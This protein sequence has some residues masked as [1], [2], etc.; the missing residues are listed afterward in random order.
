MKLTGLKPE[1]VFKYFEEIS[2]V[3]RGSGN[4]NDIADYCMEFANKNSLKAFRD[5]ANNIIIFKDATNGYENSAPV[6]LQGHLDIVCQKEEGNAI[7]FEKDGLDIYVDGDYITARGTTLGADNGIAIAMIMAILESS[8]LSHPPIEAI[9]TT[10]E[11]I[12]MI[13]ASQLD[14]SQIKGTRMINLD[15]EEQDKLTVSCAG[16]SEFEITIPVIRK[17]MDGSIVIL[18]LVGLK[19]GHSGIEIGSG[20]VNASI[21]AGRFLNAVSNYEIISINGG[22]KSNAITNCCTV[23]L[24]T[25]EPEKLI[26]ALENYGETVKKEIAE[27]E[28]G[29]EI[30]VKAGDA[31]QFEVLDDRAKAKLVFALM[32]IPN[33]VQEMSA[34]IDGLVETSLNLGI[35]K[36]ET[37]KITMVSA[38]RSNKQ[39]ALDWLEEKLNNFSK[40]LEC[41]CK[42][43]G[44]YPPWEYK[45]NSP[46]QDLYKK[47]FEEK[48]GYQP[49]VEAIHAGLE[50]GTLSA[51]IIDLDCISVGPDLSDV[52]T[53]NEKLKI[54][55]AK[56]MY[57][58]VKMLL[59]RMK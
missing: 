33:G 53:T 7:D 44:H 6:I 19:G 14:A 31:G 8:D 35:L 28:P 2:A 4:M 24:L 50:C 42:T 11:E 12:G 25:N 45:E 32:F 23:Q 13:G 36:T 16:G 59:Q 26:S 40:S 38:L 34:S 5:D 46:L 22:D 15:S 37:D 30:S 55:S 47:C 41:S 29:I 3:P 1:K 48:F 9:F 21:L 27:R 10:D 18:S 17:K 49:T 20:R 54:S 56:E 57:E 52:H 58:I 39:S 51:K 43:S